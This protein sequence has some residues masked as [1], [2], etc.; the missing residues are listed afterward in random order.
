MQ[1]IIDFFIRNKNFLLFSI[2]FLISITLTI[3]SHSFH[4][5]K[6][7]SAA[8]VVSGN[9]YSAKND[10]TSY[11]NLKRKNELLVDENLR[12]RNLLHIRKDQS[13]IPVLDSGAPSLKYNFTAARVI[14]N[15]YARTKNQLTLNKG[16]KD[17]IA[18]EMGVISQNG[19]V[20]IVSNVSENYATVQ[21]ILNTNSQI[22]AN[23][24]KSGH[25]GIL[26][27]DAKDPDVVQLVDVPRIAPVAVGDTV[28][29]DG[30]STIFPKGIP[31][32]TIKEFSL[33]EDTNY[34]NLD[35]DLFNDMTSLE[36]V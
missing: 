15:S 8:N 35:I 29:T 27:W 36:Y 3:R 4:T 28:T 23:I 31:I 1:Q 22:S 6:F 5:N 20:G 12:L 10:L 13:P 11:F 24:K 26:V 30:R 32:G 14:N 19:I 18:K 25:F 33:T 2:L 9:I 17:G 21:S 34:Y 7:V 16:S